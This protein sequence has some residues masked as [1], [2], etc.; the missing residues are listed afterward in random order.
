MCQLIL[1]R[2][3]KTLKKG[4]TK[5]GDILLST[6]GEI[7]KIAY[8]TNE[9]INCNINAQLV[10]INGGEEYSTFYLG[11]LFESKEY[12]EELLSSTTG[13]ALQQLPRK[14]LSFIKLI[15]PIISTIQEFSKRYES[16]H[17]TYILK[18]EENQKLLELKELLL[19]KMTRVNLV[20][21]K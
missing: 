7:G 20:N 16:I 5:K 3:N 12:K 8:V 19:A 15:I 9:F 4:H 6:R 18:N 1:G 14:N 11:C 13:S 10:R 21:I 2:F 17:T